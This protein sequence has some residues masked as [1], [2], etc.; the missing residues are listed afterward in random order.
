[1]VGSGEVF[2]PLA[3]LLDR[4]FGGQGELV[5]L[6]LGGGLGFGRAQRRV[7]LVGVASA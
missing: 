6:G 7:V 3:R 2:D 1:V 4:L 5:A